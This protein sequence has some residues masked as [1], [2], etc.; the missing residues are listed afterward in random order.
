MNKEQ[1]KVESLVAM[2]KLLQSDATYSE[3]DFHI[4][5]S[6]DI[7]VLSAHIDEDVSSRGYFTPLKGTATIIDKDYWSYDV[8]F[9]C[10]ITVIEEIAYWMSLSDEKLSSI[11]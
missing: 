4:I 9:L 10:P 2:K 7:V 11:T 3:H 8:D 6:D 5:K 1:Y